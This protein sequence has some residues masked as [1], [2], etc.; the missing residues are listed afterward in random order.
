MSRKKRKKR[1][2]RAVFRVNKKISSLESKAPSQ[3]TDSLTYTR[4]SAFYG[5]P[6]KTR[7]GFLLVDCVIAKVG[8]LEYEYINPETGESF[9]L[10]EF[11]TAEDIFSRECMASANGAP[12]VNDHPVDD[13]GEF[14]EVGKNNYNQLIKGVVLN[15][16]V[17]GDNLIGTLKIFD[18]EMIE[19]I[20]SKKLNEVSIG[21]RCQ[22][23][24][25]PGEFL[26]VKYDAIH[27]RTTIN[28]LALVEE[29][30]AGSDVRVLFDSRTHKTNQNEVNKMTEE[31]AAKML[32]LMA[33][34]AAKLDAMSGDADE[35]KEKL[36]DTDNPGHKPEDKKEDM[37]HEEEP[38]KKNGDRPESGKT[39]EEIEKEILDS[40]KFQQRLQADT[41]QAILLQRQA[42]AVLGDDYKVNA[43]A[44]ALRRAVIKKIGIFAE[45]EVEK[46]NGA[47]LL[48]HFNLSYKTH[49]S[50]VLESKKDTQPEQ[51][52]ETVNYDIDDALQ[53]A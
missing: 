5:K 39:S 19:A 9:K 41:S 18:A 17:D 53:I 14:V 43:D 23:V 50:K 22:V 26:G 16:R 20:E 31:Q 52:G 30:R 45:V 35:D 37:E 40:A 29:G 36:E 15:P 33:A 7:E 11:K 38:K 32:E 6:E 10:N 47:N 1:N 13:K 24:N 8:V 51:T 3:K 4:R 34:M 44:D 42:V 49:Q 12:F 27:K 2:L 28:H 21:F 25:E 46:L 48:A